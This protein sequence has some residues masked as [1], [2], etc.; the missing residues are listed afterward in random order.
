MPAA[1]A[2]SM[3]TSFFLWHRE[4]RLPASRCRVPT[5]GRPGCL[6][7]DADVPVIDGRGV[8]HIGVVVV[9]LEQDV[10]DDAV[11]IEPNRAGKTMVWPYYSDGKLIYI[12]CF[13]P[14]D[15]G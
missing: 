10:P 11:V 15:M 13:M 1:V 4:Y 5:L 2:A 3:S 6:L 14:G 12:R 9:V 8:E 7:I